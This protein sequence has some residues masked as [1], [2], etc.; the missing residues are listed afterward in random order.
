MPRTLSLSPFPNAA[1][2][3]LLP[4]WKIHP[5]VSVEHLEKHAE[6]DPFNHELA[7]ALPEPSDGVDP[8]WSTFERVV[9]ERKRGRGQR[10]GFLLRRKGMDMAWDEWRPETEG[11]A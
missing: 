6:G 4:A 11:Q 5:V 7:T 9:S 1:R 3:A 2:L 8:V 10:R